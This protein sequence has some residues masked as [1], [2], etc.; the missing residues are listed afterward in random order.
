MTK[1]MRT[2]PTAS[3]R[4]TTNSRTTALRL[5]PFKSSMLL[6]KPSLN[7]FCSIMQAKNTS[8]VGIPMSTRAATSITRP[9]R[10]AGECRISYMTKLRGFILVRILS[11]R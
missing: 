10:A 2:R 7:C 4:F 5:R 1:C 11:S 9:S 8:M 3:P 6:L